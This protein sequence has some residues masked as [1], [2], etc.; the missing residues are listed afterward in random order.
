MTVNDG[1]GG[2]NYN[3]SYVSNTTS[4][5]NPASLTVE[6]PERHQDLRRHADGERQRR[7]WSSG[8][9]YHNVSNGGAQ[10]I[11]Q[12]R[13]LAFTEP[14][15]GSGDKTVTSGGVTVND[16]NGGGNYVLTY[17]NNTTSTINPAPLTFVGT[18]PTRPTTRTTAATLS[19]YTLPASSA[20]RR[21]D[22]NAGAANFSDPNAGV[23]KTVTISGITLANGTNG[24]LAS[25]YIVNAHRQR[26]RPRSIR[27]C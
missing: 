13:Q 11:L 22:A 17:A 27:R 20:A 4:T 1:N 3:V 19:G 2:G 7:R 5:I 12:R 26:H 9:L 18:S 23:G 24:G 8:T 25:N 10:D 14:N 16:G 6:R 15:A 21:V